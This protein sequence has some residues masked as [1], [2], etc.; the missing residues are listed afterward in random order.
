MGIPLLY[1]LKR[2]VY[3]I[4]PRIPSSTAPC[5]A[6]CQKNLT[7]IKLTTCYNQRTF[8]YKK[9]ILHYT[10]P[11]HH[12]WHMN[13][14]SILKWLNVIEIVITTVQT[15]QACSNTVIWIKTQSNVR[16]V[17][18]ETF[19]AL[20]TTRTNIWMKTQTY[21]RLVSLETF[22]ACSNTDISI[23]ILN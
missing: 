12:A 7:A 15:F 14:Q 19:L 16:L 18:F 13:V 1:D 8:K 11:K 6:D 4:Y 9:A 23:K 2:W 17:A 10:F 22:Q 21:V 3:G 5:L 20:S